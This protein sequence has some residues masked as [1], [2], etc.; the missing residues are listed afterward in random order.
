MTARQVALALG[1]KNMAAGH[2]FQFRF[3]ARHHCFS[4]RPVSGSMS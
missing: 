1:C 2:E 4:L 3:V